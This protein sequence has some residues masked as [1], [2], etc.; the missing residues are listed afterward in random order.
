MILYWNKMSVK[1]DILQNYK[2]K[3]KTQNKYF[4]FVYIFFYIISAF[5]FFPIYNKKYEINN[6]CYNYLPYTCI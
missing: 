1:I 5:S 3:M 2:N 6:V 4:C